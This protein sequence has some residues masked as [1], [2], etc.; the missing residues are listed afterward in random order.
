MTGDSVID[1]DKL[2]ALLALI[3]NDGGAALGI[4][5]ASVG[6]DLGLWETLGRVGPCTP[7]TLAQATGTHERMVTEWL[8]AQAAGGY[9]TYDHDTGSF[10]LSP[11]Q[12]FVLAEPN[13]PAAMGG[14]FQCI[15]AWSQVLGKAR[16]AF[17]RQRARVGRSH[18][19]GVSGNRTL[20]PTPLRSQ[21]RQHLD[22][23]PPGVWKP[24]CSPARPLLMSAA[25]MVHQPSSWPTR[26]PTRRSPASTSTNRRSS[27]PALSLRKQA[28]P[29]GSP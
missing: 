11:E 23:R 26:F 10:S 15:A 27:G 22:P 12:A 17:H 7:A 5:L 14:L 13:S 20:L 25:A 9:V 16:H 4:L 28:S 18:A 19:R 2:G 8:S 29:A 21:P 24:S 1:Q 6:D 3:V